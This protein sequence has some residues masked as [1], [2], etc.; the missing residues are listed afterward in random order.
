VSESRND[1]EAL[2]RAFAA[3]EQSQGTMNQCPAPEQL[4]E[5]ASGALDREQQ[6][7]IVDH[8]SQCA[9]CTQ[10]W[11]LAMELG[12]RPPSHVEQSRPSLFSRLRLRTIQ[13]RQFALA[14]SVICAV[15]LTAYLVIPAIIPVTQQPPQYRDAAH[16]MAPVSLVTG[17]L[18]RDRFLLRW[19]A[20]PQGSTY[21]LR[22][23]TIDLAPLLVQQDL[24]RAE[25]VAPSAALANVESGE[26]LLWQ[27]EVR[28]PDGQRIASETYVVT[29]E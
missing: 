21:L 6:L 19:S 9:E 13:A 23:T 25:F 11:R 7:R 24:T 15:G 18:A 28:L 27:V 3:R 8:V 4:F 22:L 26:Q 14:A 17:S 5:A 16:P 2:A 20:G 10:A 29:V 1:F 12:A